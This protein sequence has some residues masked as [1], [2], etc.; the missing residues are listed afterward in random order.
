MRLN[1]KVLFLSFP[2]VIIYVL[3]K[4]LKGR[5]LKNMLSILCD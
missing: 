3:Q 5:M 1:T 4:F 2:I